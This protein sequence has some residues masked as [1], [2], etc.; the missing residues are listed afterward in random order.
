[1]QSTGSDSARH[2]FLLARGGP[3][4]GSQRQMYYLVRGLDRRRYEPIVVLDRP[5]QFE[6][7]LRRDGVQTH[8]V[9]VH[10][11][12]GFPGSLLRYF[13]A[14]GLARL[15]RRTGAALVHASDVWRSGYMHFVARRLG[16]PSVLHIRGPLSRRDILKHEVAGS[17]AVIP[18]ALRYQED[19]L[20]AGVAPDRIRQI[21][22]AV[23]L[24]QFRPDAAGREAIRR[25]FGADDHVLV[26]LIGRIEP[27]K[28]VLEF[29]EAIAPLARDGRRRARFLVIGQPGR[30]PYYEAVL[31][32]TER[33]GLSDHV[34]FTGRW[35]D[36]PA[37]M[38]A[39]DVVVTMS[40]GSVMFEAQ[41]CAKP[42]LSVRTDGRH[43]VHTIHDQTALCVTTDRPEPTT[44]ALARLID[45]PAL[46][47]RLGL[48][49]RAHA[50]AHLS[51]ALM[52]QRTQ[53]VYDELLG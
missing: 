46:R 31:A 40:G 35:D 39:L 11:W 19:L 20:A 42:V 7:C 21:D 50:E 49:G 22:D 51:P 44:E 48:A 3:L 52:A 4:D 6:D 5:G 43:Y 16:V 18:I 34:T 53:A 27:F 37:M 1:M 36:M 24:E 23:D 10:S 2:A 28:R 25:R 45:D 8:V 17:S 26:G 32:A 12:R 33:L 15:A 13:D 38:A 47:L 14:F 30:P 41:A 9:A 29:L